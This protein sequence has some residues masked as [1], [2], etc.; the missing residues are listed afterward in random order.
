[1]LADL[2]Y[3]EE[4]TQNPKL[5]VIFHNP[6][7]VYII[8]AMVDILLDY[9]LFLLDIYRIVMYNVNGGYNVRKN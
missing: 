3:S 4:K 7:G 6:W 8:R 1:M 9:V 5:L 2:A